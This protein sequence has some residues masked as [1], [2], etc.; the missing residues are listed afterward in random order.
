MSSSATD[1][2]YW[3]FQ[4]PSA[5]E[6]RDGRPPRQAPSPAAELQR[7][8]AME[9]LRGLW[10]Q[11]CGEA[12]Q[13]P[14]PPGDAFDRWLYAQL[15]VPAAQC[16]TRDPLLKRPELALET[17]VLRRELEKELPAST[18]LSWNARNDPRRV[19]SQL[20]AYVEASRRWL[21][22]QQQQQ[23]VAVPPALSEALEQAA[24]LGR[25]SN[26]AQL[27]RARLQ[28]VAA[29][30]QPAVRGAVSGKIDSM[31][32]QLV[33]EAQAIC[34]QLG[35]GKVEG[36]AGSVAGGAGATAAA[37]VAASS[38]GDS[39]PPASA[40][41]SS[42]APLAVVV[43]EEGRREVQLTF[44]GDVQRLRPLHFRKLCELFARHNAGAEVGLRNA[45][46]YC[47]ARRYATLFGPDV[48]KSASMHAALPDFGFRLLHQRLGVVHENYASPFNCF[49]ATFNS[50]FGDTDS[51]LGSLG[52]FADCFPVEGSFETGPP[53]TEEVMD[54]MA[55]H[56]MVV[57]ES[58]DRPLSF[59]VFVPDW[60]QPLLEA[61]RIMEASRFL[62]DQLVLK[63]RQHWYVVGHQ[64]QAD[65]R[66]DDRFFELPMDTHIYVLQND[67]GAAKWPCKG[68]LKALAETMEQQAKVLGVGH[69]SGGDRKRNAAAAAASGGAAYE[70]GGGG[71]G[72]GPRPAKQAPPST[73]PGG[74]GAAAPHA[75]LPVAQRLSRPGPGGSSLG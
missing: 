54:Q 7:A 1:S 52:S 62:R 32:Q 27:L 22:Q 29:K 25:S 6:F 26:D 35:T 48:F 39:Q 64:H 69:R 4:L 10:R 23:S 15:M 17:D 65:E 13:L 63:G 50:A 75:R 43:V 61:Q 70:S 42:S 20:C 72:G 24:Q 3:D 59:V 56:L 16:S 47:V 68:V 49:F 36:A 12:L 11:W 30:V 74:A 33:A 58:S 8:R 2:F 21:R 73:G 60:R 5:N 53:Y 37:A 40:A 66:A 45:V 31:M 41:A 67:A 38:G 19:G 71:G 18:Y 51:W 28:D 34:A 55:R 46:L 57:L 14:Q 9:R 44:D